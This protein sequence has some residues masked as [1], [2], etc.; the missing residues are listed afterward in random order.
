MNFAVDVGNSFAKIGIFDQNRLLKV[1]EQ[2]QIKNLPDLVNEIKPAHLIYSSVSLPADDFIRQINP[3]L[4]VLVLE[5]QTGLPIKN[6]Y[7]S[8]ETLGMD[9]LAS[10]V[11]A[12]QLFAGEDVLV[13]DC[14]T[15]IKY[16]FVDKE[17]VY[18][19]G[20]ISPGLQMKIKSLH[21]FTAQLPLVQ[22]RQQPD[23]VGKTTKES[24]LSGVVNGTAAE[25]NGIISKFKNQNAQITVLLSGGDAHFLSNQIDHKHQLEPFLPLKGLNY[26]LMYNAEKMV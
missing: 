21:N 13:V 26:I 3:D 6:N 22:L 17:G 16:D 24:I 14:G 8:P 18:F 25:I 5:H 11:A 10:A 2:V 9:R 4:E 19:G 20:A 15:C 23:L 7:K 1:H 12:S